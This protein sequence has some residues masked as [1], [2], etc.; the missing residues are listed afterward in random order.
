LILTVLTLSSCSQ[1]EK[2]VVTEKYTDGSKKKVHFYP[3]KDDQFYYL[4]KFYHQNGQLGSEGYIK[5]D[6]MTGVWNWW[7]ENGNPE[8]HSTYKTGQAKDSSLCYYESGQLSRK[9]YQVDTIRDI[10]YSTDYFENGQKKIETYLVGNDRVVDS[11]WREW[12]PQGQLIQEGEMDST[13]K[14]GVWE[15]RDDNDSLMIEEMDGTQTI[16][17][18]E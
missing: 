6:K 12:N 2:E 7:Y 16:T 17:F 14:V 1:K 11:I 9:L 18:N 10:W 3:D 5:D 8:A 13:K 4:E 15:I